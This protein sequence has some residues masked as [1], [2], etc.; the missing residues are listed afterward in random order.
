[1]PSDKVKMI[2]MSK[3]DFS[4]AEIDSMTEAQCWEWVYANKT[5]SQAD[6]REQI[7]FTGFRP[8]EKEA[9]QSKAE[10][11]E[12]KVV[13]SVSKKLTYLCIGPNA[14]PKK[15]EKAREQGVTILTVDQ[16]ESLITT[17]ELS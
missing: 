1:M 5:P 4:E 8:A 9:L 15:M 14:G 2:L 11:A 13:K 16:F 7:C 10:A 3:S 12:M 17:G 6:T